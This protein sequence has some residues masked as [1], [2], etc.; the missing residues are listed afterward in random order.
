VLDL[1]DSAPKAEMSVPLVLSFKALRPTLVLPLT[2]P[3]PIPILTPLIVESALIEAF[4]II[5]TAF[6]LPLVL[7]I[8]NPS[9]LPPLVIFKAIPLPLECPISTVFPLPELEKTPLAA[10]KVCV[11]KLTL[12]VAPTYGTNPFKL[13]HE[14]PLLVEDNNCPEVPI[15]PEESFRP[16]WTSM[17]LLNFIYYILFLY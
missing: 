11:P 17:S 3:D 2:F 8:Y 9:P 14:T 4:P 15:A 6:P 16:A 10:N 13:V 12:A 7:L 5:V 1:S